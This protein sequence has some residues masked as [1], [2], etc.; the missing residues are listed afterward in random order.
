MLRLRS[1]IERLHAL[2]KERRRRYIDRAGYT[3]A[4]ILS[5]VIVLLM[6]G[7]RLAPVRDAVGL[8]WIIR[9]DSRQ[10]KVFGDCS[11]PEN[12]SLPVCQSQERSRVEKDWKDIRNRGDGKALPFS[13]FGR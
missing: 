11:R 5:F 8:G 12:R 1:I 9:K 6:G 7:E 2:P 13:L 4:L 3:I 10:G